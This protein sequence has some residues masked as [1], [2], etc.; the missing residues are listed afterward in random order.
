MKIE[1]NRFNRW[2][3]LDIMFKLKTQALDLKHFSVTGVYYGE[4]FLG[5]GITSFENNAGLK[6]IYSHKV[7][8]DVKI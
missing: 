3:N 6:N 2:Q 1:E 5:I 7:S 8:Y 4:Q